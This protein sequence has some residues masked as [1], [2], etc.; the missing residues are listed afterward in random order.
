MNAHPRRPWR[1]L[2]PGGGTSCERREGRRSTPA[3][4]RYL[5]LRA[6]EASAGQS[7]HRLVARP[8]K[9]RLRLA[10]R[11][12]RRACLHPRDSSTSSD[13]LVR[14]PPEPGASCEPAGSLPPCFQWRNTSRRRRRR[15]GRDDSARIRVSRG[16]PPRKINIIFRCVI[17]IFGTFRCC[18]G[19]NIKL[20]G[21]RER[22]SSRS[23]SFR[24]SSVSP[25]IIGLQKCG[26]F[27]SKTGPICVMSADST[28]EKY[29]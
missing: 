1:A 3:G 22:A 8:R 23:R 18:S 14:I 10:A 15:R 27:D 5:V 12:C 13:R 9:T 25:R 19:D 21:N 24:L 11:R 17:V 26:K 2:P 16:G 6:A 20:L 4:R 7:V 29:V 28:F